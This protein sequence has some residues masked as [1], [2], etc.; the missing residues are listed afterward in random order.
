[1]SRRFGSDYDLG[2]RRT[3]DP[4]ALLTGLFLA[5]GVFALVY[6]IV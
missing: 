3:P 2:D 1:M 6:L 4:R 5:V